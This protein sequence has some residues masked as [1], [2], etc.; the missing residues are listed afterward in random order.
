MEAE[1]RK[2]KDWD[3]PSYALLRKKG[4]ITFD[5]YSHQNDL[6]SA[7]LLNELHHVHH[8][9]FEGL[10]DISECAVHPGLFFCGALWREHGILHL[11]LGAYL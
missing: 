4:A 10:C 3:T 5:P 9:F 7:Y 11:D 1:S 6:Y 2:L 8:A